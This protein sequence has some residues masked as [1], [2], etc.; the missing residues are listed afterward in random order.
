MT[1]IRDIYRVAREEF[2]LF[3]RFPKTLIS[4]F[5]ISLVPALYLLIYI[6]SVWDPRPFP[7]S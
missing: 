5:G 7:T 2:G 6:S 3:K 4:A 1:V